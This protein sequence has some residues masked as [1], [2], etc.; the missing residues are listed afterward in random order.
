MIF[1]E[2]FGPHSPIS[3]LLPQHD[4]RLHKHWEWEKKFHYSPAW[5]TFTTSLSSACVKIGKQELPPNSLSPEGM[6]SSHYP[7]W[8][9][10]ANF[11]KPFPLIWLL[12]EF[13]ASD[14]NFS[15]VLSL[16]AYSGNKG[17]W[18]GYLLYKLPAPAREYRHHYTEVLLDELH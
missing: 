16:V 5:S 17:K 15:V 10:Y 11:H 14:T 3:H 18:I 8:Q 4:G 7:L 9:C 2:M 13:G 1:I 6:G 12:L